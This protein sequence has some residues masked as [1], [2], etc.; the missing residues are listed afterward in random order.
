MSPLHICVVLRCIFFTETNNQ[1]LNPADMV[2][3]S[4]EHDGGNMGFKIRLSVPAQ[5]KFGS[6][7]CLIK[8]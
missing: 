5:M 2:A 3:L 1:I 4:H 6:S 7:V 8:H